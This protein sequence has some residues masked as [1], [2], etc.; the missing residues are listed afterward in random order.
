[1]HPSNCRAGVLVRR[2]GHGTGVQHDDLRVG[3]V[4]GALKAAILELALDR[5]A[6][7]L[8]R[9]TTKILY[10]KTSHAT[11]VAAQSAPA[12]EVRALFLIG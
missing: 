6:V 12:V 10:V 2:G 9:T 4:R 3:E 5:S 8:R 7:S 1:M 11:I